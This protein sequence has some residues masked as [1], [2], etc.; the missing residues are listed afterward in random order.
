MKVMPLGTCIVLSLA[1]VLVFLMSTG[2]ADNT[3]INAP[4][5]WSKVCSVSKD[6]K[7][8]QL[9]TDC[10]KQWKDATNLSSDAYAMIP[11][12]FPLIKKCKAYAKEW[13]ATDLDVVCD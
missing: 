13:P 9:I 3:R 6:P 5:V 11:D 1:S 7:L 10:G 12:N 2:I 8:L 4:A